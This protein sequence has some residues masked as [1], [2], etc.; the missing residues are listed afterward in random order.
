M[1]CKRMLSMNP[2]FF[3]GAVVEGAVAG[4]SV[5]PRSA[6]APGGG[7]RTMTVNSGSA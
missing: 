2:D 1:R 5:D 4:A 3:K 7:F 6:Q